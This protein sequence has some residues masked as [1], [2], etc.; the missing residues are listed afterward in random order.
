MKK[1]IAFFVLLAMAVSQTAFA[2][3]AV[4]KLKRGAEGLF[5]SPLEISNE[6]RNTRA[7]D[8]NVAESM[9]TGVFVGLIMTGKRII[10]GAYDIVTFPLNCPR[11][12]RLLLADDY[13]TALA[14]HRALGRVK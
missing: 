14:E 12:Y 2:G 11:T 10:N 1:G 9:A 7:A 8:G 6:Y 3:A 13:P 5:T 4:D